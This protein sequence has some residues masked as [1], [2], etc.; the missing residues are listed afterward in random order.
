MSWI[1]SAVYFFGI[2]LPAAI[3]EELKFGARSFGRLADGE[4]QFGS[5]IG[6]GEVAL[7]DSAAVSP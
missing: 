6:R 1:S 5:G 7:D 2:G 4:F 3:Y